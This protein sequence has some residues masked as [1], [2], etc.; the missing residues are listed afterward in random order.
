MHYHVSQPFG[1]QPL[2]SPLQLVVTLRTTGFITQKFYVL[3]E[4]GIYL[5]GVNL[6][7]NSH[8][9]YLISFFNPDE[10]VTARYRPSV[11]AAFDARLVRVRFV[12]DKV[13][14][15]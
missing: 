6:R 13:T 7:T 9:V 3:P 4:E 10:G 14:M 5:C 15:G 12:V 11:E 8:N 1:S 2:C